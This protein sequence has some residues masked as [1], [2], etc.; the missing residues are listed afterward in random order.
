MTLKERVK[1]AVEEYLEGKDIVLV[2]LKCT[3]DSVIE[4]TLDSLNGVDLDKCVE[5]SRFI[6]SKL[7]RDVEDFELTV[8]SASISEPFTHPIQYKK[9]ISRQIEIMEAGSRSK[10]SATL[11]DVDDEGITVSYTEK[12]VPEGKKRKEEVERV[13][14]ISFEDIKSAKLHF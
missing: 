6:E 2:S 11:N 5:A 7:D 12:I 1:I 8:G 3:P 9:N 13:R 4:V 14:K 10:L